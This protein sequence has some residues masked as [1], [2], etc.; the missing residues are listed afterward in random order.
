MTTMHIDILN[1][2]ASKLLKD[3]AELNLISIR[4]STDNG[5]MSVV[6]KIRAKANT[7]PPTLAEITE[8][9]EFVRAARYAKEKK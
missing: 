3:L 4:K 7:N 1:P 8:E 2:K 6:K 9:V 5:F